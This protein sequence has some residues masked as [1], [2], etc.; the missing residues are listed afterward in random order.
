[1]RDGGGGGEEGVDQGVGWG[2][3][4]GGGGERGQMTV[5]EKGVTE[6]ALQ[7]LRSP[8]FSLPTLSN[9]NEVTDS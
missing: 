7:G 4:G 2:E 1:M 6:T 3:G 8:F 5:R 9:D